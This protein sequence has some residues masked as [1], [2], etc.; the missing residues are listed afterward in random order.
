MRFI[1]NAIQATI[2]A[3]SFYFALLWGSE[4]MYVLWSPIYG[5]GD[6]VRSQVVFGYGH[7]FDLTS[8][9]LFRLAAFLAACKLAASLVFAIHIV[10][11]VRAFPDGKIDYDFLEAALLLLVP[12]TIAMTIPAIVEHSGN[13]IR[14]HGTYLLLAGI[15][16]ALSAVERL[17]AAASEPPQTRAGQ[18]EAQAREAA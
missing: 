13:L 4:A 5:L 11:R 3:I 16:A 1:P 8:L 15:L 6:Y 10:E 12:L 7:I 18:L 14:L 17:V 9:G 2:V